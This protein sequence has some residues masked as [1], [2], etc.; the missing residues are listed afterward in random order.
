MLAVV[1]LMVLWDCYHGAEHGP[2]PQQAD[3]DTYLKHAADV[4]APLAAPPT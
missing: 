2:Q 3:R 1:M 4:A